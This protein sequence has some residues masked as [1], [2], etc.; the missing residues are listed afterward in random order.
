MARFFQFDRV[1]LVLALL[2]LSL[3]ISSCS[4]SA[5]SLYWG[6]TQL[7][8][9][10]VL[11]YVSGGQPETL[12]PQI[13]SS[14]PEARINMALFDG[15][16]EYDPKD[17]QPIPAI[18]ESWESSTNWD[19]FVFHLRKNAKWSD[20]KPITARDF[21]YSFRRGFAPETL[22]RTASL[23][24]FITY[25]EA[26]NGKQLFVQRNN[27][28]VLAKDLAEEP[29]AVKPSASFGQET[30]FRKFIKSPERVTVSSDTLKR[31]QAVEA[32]PKLK[33]VF[34][35]TTADL[36][37]AP[38]LA[39]KIKSGADELTKFLSA[40]LPA[41]ALACAN[42]N[43]CTDAAKQSLADNLN[44][45]LDA[46]S[47]FA[48]D[49]FGSVSVSPDAK[50]L[51]D[52]LAAE[53]KKRAEANAKIDEEIAALEDEAKKAEK[54]KTKKK[55]IGKLF[56]ANRFLLEQ[57][58]ADEIEPVALVPVKGEDIGAEAVD[59]YTFRIS[60]RQ[61]APFFVG[62]L[63]HQFFRL[64][65]EHEIQKYKE[66]WS[67]PKNYDTGGA[68]PKAMVSCGPFKVKEYRPY[69]V[70]IVERDPN[71]WDAAN[72]KLDRIE[73]LAPEEQSTRLNMYKAG[74]ID[75]FLNHSVPPAWID[76]IRQYE[77]EYLDFPENST[78]YYSFNVRKPPFDNQKIRQ[79]FSAALNREILSQSRKVTKPLYYYTP[80]GIFPDYDKAM[81][82]VGEEIRAE[83]KITPEDWKKRYGFDP[84]RARR[85]LTEAGYP[86][87]KSGSG[88]SCPTFPTDKVSLTFNTQESNRQIA[89]F[90]QSQWKQN[91]GITV[92]LK[93]ME[94]KTFM[95]MRN[96]VQYEGIAQSLWSGDYM[97]PFTFLGLHYGLPNDG[98][99]AFQDDKYD[100]M[101]DDAN[102]ELDP[103]KRYEKLARAEYYLVEQMP[104]MP[105]TINATNWM[106]KPYVKG[107]YPN[108]GT[109]HAWKFV[110]I[111]RDP[112][113][114]DTS[115]KN[116][117]TDK[118]PIIEEQLTKLKSTQAQKPATAE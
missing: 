86:V 71:Y 33:E 87:E 23:G 2:V 11:R 101:L 103:Q 116:I 6:K 22:S 44:K 46:D 30:E 43:A 82:K 49:W 66:N 7:P 75:A 40:N 110:Y 14:Q 81:E 117:M 115:V 57:S 118:D 41:D 64:V 8:K 104:A 108:P 85:L 28:F 72:V 3:F 97:D 67:L 25:A 111:E 20:G 38:S 37:N 77:S 59:D 42:A 84:E 80:T 56:Y 88:W 36:K 31:A 96:A 17:L 74:E 65:P 54:E 76:E 112:A 32:N 95:P 90:V 68:F 89:E 45:I 5:N 12:D 114:W 21:V 94:F 26:F 98:G 34:K 55:L 92:P 83:Q 35:L 13:P 113:K 15:L 47:L 48:K 60:L 93:N 73:F 100:K 105:L 109:L 24:Y 4:S 91:L 52:A 19:E 16:V 50:K 61:P 58:F 79:A 99:S 10:N 102:A 29:P 18:A 39:G 1:R 70:L 51:A 63:A 9:E 27:Q 107:I 78:A 53:N 69:D 106:K 62:L